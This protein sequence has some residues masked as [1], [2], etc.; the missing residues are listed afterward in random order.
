MSLAAIEKAIPDAGRQIID[1]I[2]GMAVQEH[3]L[4]G[5]LGG[6]ETAGHRSVPGPSPQRASCDGEEIP[7]T[8][9]LQQDPSFGAAALGSIEE[10][11]PRKSRCHGLSMD[12][13]D[14]RPIGVPCP[15]LRAVP[16]P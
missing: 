7:G 11:L 13:P 2:G 16:T 3:R 6:K 12:G 14:Y 4:E 5:T 1:F 9:R 8:W 10:C 15:M